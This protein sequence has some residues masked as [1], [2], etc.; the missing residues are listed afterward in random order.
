MWRAQPDVAG[1]FPRLGREECE[2]FQGLENF[3]FSFP[4]IGSVVAQASG[5]CSTAGTAVPRLPSRSANVGAQVCCAQGVPSAERAGAASLRPYQ[6][7]MF[8]A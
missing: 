8:H 3:Q 2:F 5:L 4:R 7:R 6:R 1:S